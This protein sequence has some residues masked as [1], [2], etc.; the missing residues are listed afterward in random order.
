MSLR[1]SRVRLVWQWLESERQSREGSL[2]MKYECEV[3]VLQHFSIS[4]FQLFSILPFNLSFYQSFIHSF[5]SCRI[6]KHI[7]LAQNNGAAQSSFIVHRQSFVL[8][9]ES[10]DLLRLDLTR[11]DMTWRLGTCFMS[12]LVLSMAS[13]PFYSMLF[14]GDNANDKWHEQRDR[15]WASQSKRRNIKKYLEISTRTDWNTFIIHSVRG[16]VRYFAMKEPNLKICRW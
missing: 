6:K 14:C 13:L 9:L 7:W 2:R 8:S 4:A 16:Q 5:I 1:V 10:H 12:S 3:T 15:Q 11:R